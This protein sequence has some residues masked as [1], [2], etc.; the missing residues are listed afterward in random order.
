MSA[1]EQLKLDIVVKISSGLIGRRE[2]QRIL[3]VSERTLRRYLKDYQHEGVLAVKHGNYN[4]A[5]S[6]RSDNDLKIQVQEL[7][8]AKYYDFNM[9]HCL[10]KLKSVEKITLTRETFRL[11]CHEIKM[12]KRAKRRSSKVRR[13]RNRMQQTG[14]MLQMDGSPHDWFGGKPSCLIGAIDDADSDVPFAEF[15]PAEDTISCMRVLEQ[16]IRKKGLFHILYVDKAGI[17]GGQKRAHF[18]QVKRALK[19]LNIE[20]IFANSPEAKGRIERLWGTLQDRLIPEMRIRG[21]HTYEAANCFLQ[22]QYLPV[23]YAPKFKVQPANLQTAYRPVPNGIDLH[24]I[25]CLKEY[26]SVKRDHTF[27]WGMELYRIDSPLKR[28]IWKQ[29]IEIRT[30][31]DL[32]WKAFFAGKELQISLVSVPARAELEAVTSLP[33]ANVSPLDPQRVRCDGHVP[34]L[35]RYYSVDESFLEKRVSIS[36]RDGQIQIY[37]KGKLIETHSKLTGDYAQ[38]STKPEHMG[39]W[40]RALEPMSIYRKN[41]RRIGLKTEELIEIILK[42]GQGFIDT[43]AIWGIIGFQKN[44]CTLSVNEACRKALEMESPTYRAVKTL[45]KLHANRYEQRQQTAV[46]A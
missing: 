30:Y 29:K 12:V 14:L 28:S 19:E 17:F 43:G 3:N 34:Y 21:I 22:E 37:H 26:R 44:Y 25:F 32:T 39:P 8:R 9:L 20:I 23:E 38:C 31:Q 10:E 45:L 16:I 33:L 36:E 15:F 40:K 7:V 5:P 42:R 2:G 46:N 13:Q 24:E 35:N 4:R 41:A 6:N 18:S 27:S 11:W 1:Q